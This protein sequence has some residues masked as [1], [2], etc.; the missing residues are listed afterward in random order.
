V[1]KSKQNGH[2]EKKFPSNPDVVLYNTINSL[3]MWRDFMKEADKVHLSKMV[4]HLEDWISK[5]DHRQD[6]NSDIAVL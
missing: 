5:R 4:E 6:F 3:Q 1:E 2:R